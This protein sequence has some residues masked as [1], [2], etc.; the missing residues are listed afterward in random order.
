M[1]LKGVA[2]DSMNFNSA[3]LVNLVVT[4]PCEFGNDLL[5][6]YANPCAGLPQTQEDSRS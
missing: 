5:V 3:E 4:E 2:C 6:S 1:G